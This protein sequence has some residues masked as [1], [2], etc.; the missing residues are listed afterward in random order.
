MTPMPIRPE[1]RKYYGHAWRKFRLELIEQAGGEI[2][3]VCLHQ[4]KGVNGAHTGHD[5]R[6]SSSVVLM[7]P[8]DHARHD[9]RHRMAIMRRRRATATGQLWLLP[10]L[11]WAPFAVWE[12]PGWIYDRIR[13]I[14]LFGGQ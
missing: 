7:C 5:P 8:R 10:E 9:A 2:C 3:S 6:D 4:I 13:Q 14:P 11:E 12:I 1:H